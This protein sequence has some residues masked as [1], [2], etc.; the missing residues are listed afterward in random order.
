LRLQFQG[1]ICEEKIIDIAKRVQYQIKSQTSSVKIYTSYIESNYRTP[2]N[3]IQK[4]HLV[5]TIK[6]FN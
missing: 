3:I 1:T 4:M 5:V 2:T 6:L